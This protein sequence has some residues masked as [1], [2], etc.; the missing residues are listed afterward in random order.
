MQQ[1]P[2]P[3]GVRFVVLKVMPIPTGAAQTIVLG[4]DHAVSDCYVCSMNQRIGELPAREQ[5]LV[6][7]G[8][9][10][11]HAFDSSLPGW[12]V[13]VPTRHV[14]G[15]HELTDGEATAMGDLL[16]SLSRALREVVGCDK[17]YTMLFAEAHGFGH[18][19]FHI[20]PRMSTF[21]PEQ[22]GPQVFTFV[23]RPPGERL[24]EDEQDEVARRLTDV[25]QRAG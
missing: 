6:D 13:L 2:P 16:V 22:I 15:L 25:L 1:H 20:V 5:I 23:G 10:A 8:W 3:S 24:S 4:Q 19:H 14:T 9:R 7:R 17:T 21:K 18:V 11:A 12:L